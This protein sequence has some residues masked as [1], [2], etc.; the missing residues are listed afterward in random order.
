M[1]FASLLKCGVSTGGGLQNNDQLVKGSGNSRGGEWGMGQ[2]S[3]NIFGIFRHVIDVIPNFNYLLVAISV[4]DDFDTTLVDQST[5][6]GIW[7][8]VCSALRIPK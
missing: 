2:S 8:V 1:S 6:A 5:C 3:I 7:Y 4:I